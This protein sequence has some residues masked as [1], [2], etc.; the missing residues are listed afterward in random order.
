[1]AK[2]DK[3]KINDQVDDEDIV[4]EDEEILDE[5]E[6]DESE[7][8]DD[9]VENDDEDD[10]DESAASDTLRPN[11]KPIGAANKSSAVGKIINAVAGMDKETVNKFVATMEL[12]GK[13]DKN[14]PAGDAAKNKNTLNTKPSNAG[15]QLVTKLEAVDDSMAEI[16]REDVA[17]IFDGEEITEEFKT[18]VTTLIESVINMKADARIV[19][20]QEEIEAKFEEELDTMATGLVEMMDAWL[21]ATTND[22]LA[23]NQVAI[24]STIKNELTEQFIE[25]LKALFETHY[26]DVPEDRVDV[27]AEMNDRIEELERMVSEKIS[28]NEELQ[29]QIDTMSAEN[30]LEEMSEGLTATEAEKLTELAESVEFSDVNEFVSKIGILREQ[31]FGTESGKKSSSSRR[32][33]NVLFE[34]TDVMEEDIKKPAVTG[35]MASYVN[36]LSR[37]VRK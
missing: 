19:E 10:L 34:E 17:N 4:L 33:S 32:S 24:D 5:S 37:T 15:V 31:Y 29:D 8:L 36:S 22:W 26:V 23:E 28:V 3:S 20:I 7:E 14:I 25:G 11:S 1:M 30:A 12:I 13:E 18:K 2:L 9:E 6:I 21:D 16:I 35:S 27:V